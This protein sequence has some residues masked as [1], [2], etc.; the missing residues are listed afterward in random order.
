MALLFGYID[1]YELEE[2]IEGALLYQWN[3]FFLE[4]PLNFNTNN[5]LA[6]ILSALTG[7]PMHKCGGTRQDKILSDKEAERVAQKLNSYGKK[8]TNNP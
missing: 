6:A 5:Q 8:P 7:T 1:P 3:E 4:E 2:E